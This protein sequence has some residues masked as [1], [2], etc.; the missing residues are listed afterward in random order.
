MDAGATRVVDIGCGTG[1]LVAGIAGRWPGALITGLDVSAGMLAIAGR[2]VDD[3]PDGAG[4]RV[5][6]VQG[7]ADRLPFGDATFDVAVS[8][9]VLQLVP[10]RY[11]ALLEARRVLAPGG[12]LAT[13][14]WMPGGW[15]GADAAYDEA[16]VAAGLDPRNDGTSRDDPVRPEAAAARL[17]RAGFA[18]VR[19]REGGVAHRYSPEGY[20][21]F[22]RRFDDEELF[23][24]LEE[25]RRDAL[26]ADL[27]GRLRA[28]PPGGLE[29][30][31][32]VAYA[33]G[34]RSAR[35]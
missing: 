21:A 35:A 3:L 9:F 33:T 15:L 1:A 19:A 30:H 18:A 31:H 32:P 20:L 29:L 24:S 14:T 17:R 25:G 23:A 7:P 13:V 34:R 10:S 12:T 26:E 8:A 11:C 6:L 5:T 16:L 27:L 2:T 4:D 28:L 22:V